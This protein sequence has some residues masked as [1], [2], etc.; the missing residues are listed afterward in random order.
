[1]ASYIPSTQEERLEM[2]KAV[3]L[4]D[5]RDL[6]QDVPAEMLLEVGDLNIPEGKSELEVSSIVS[7][8]AA[9]NRV[10]PTVLRG[11]GASLPGGD[12][13]GHPPVHF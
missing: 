10:F 3:G 4:R 11:A 6:Y 2:L 12:E 9:K 1:M 13:P 8:M 5:Y 7:S